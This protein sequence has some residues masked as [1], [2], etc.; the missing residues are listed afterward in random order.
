MNIGG[1]IRRF[2][3]AVASIAM[4][5][6]SIGRGQEIPDDLL[7]DEHVREEFGVNQF[8]AP[9]IRKIFEDLNSLRPLPYDA[10]KRE[11][12]EKM[13]KDRSKLALSL[14]GL[15]ADGFLAV[16]AEKLLD[17]EPVGRSLLKHAK[18][19][20]AGTRLSEHTNSILE[21]GALGDWGGLKLE[22][23]KTQKDVEKEMVMIRDVDAAHL[24]S[25]GGWLRALEIGCAASL[26]PFDAKKAAVL[27]RADLAEYFVESVQMLED[28]VKDQDHMK[29]MLAGLRIIHDML[30]VPESKSFTAE[31]ITA[32]QE[33]V[34]SMNKLALA[35]QKAVAKAD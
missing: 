23:A 4:L 10:L 18:I 15:L 27:A 11:V 26:E 9:S 1:H 34:Q 13:P 6:S 7:E 22:L 24:I 25:L 29:E 14:G 8:T 2:T 12:P 19:L 3:I 17:L 33:K 16:E 28:R 30:D 31:E 20:G 35:P 5:S 21:H 32:L